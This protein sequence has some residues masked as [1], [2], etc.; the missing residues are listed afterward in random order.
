MSTVAPAVEPVVP[1]RSSG[2]AAIFEHTRYVLGENRVTAFAF[3]LLVIIVFAALFGPYVV[4][5]DPL[6]SD[7]VA[8]LKPPRLDSSNAP[9]AVIRP[10]LAH[11]Q[12]ATKANIEQVEQIVGT[13]FERAR[14]PDASLPN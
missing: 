7:T 3:G 6:A 8:A 5:Y 2:F 12:R 1:V 14:K 13:R 11:R 10:S 4:P 9:I